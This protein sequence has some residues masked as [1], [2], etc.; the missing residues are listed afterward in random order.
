M[1]LCSV[2]PQIGQLL[3]FSS[4]S[5]ISQHITT[6]V[7]FEVKVREIHPCLYEPTK[8]AIKRFGNGCSATVLYEISGCLYYLKYFIA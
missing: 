7:L 5:F 4:P 3:I 6:Q 8:E 1:S 2:H